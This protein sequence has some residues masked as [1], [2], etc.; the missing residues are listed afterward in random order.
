M[1]TNMGGMPASFS[2]LKDL[3]NLTPE[4][5]SHLVQVYAA[6]AWSTM[7]AA[8]GIWTF[9][10]GYMMGG[11][12]SLLGGIGCLFAIYATPQENQQRK[13]AFLTG[14][15]YCKGL[16]IAP[17]VAS[18]LEVDPS[19]VMYAFT[20]TTVV[21]ASFT[22]SALFA[23]RR[24]YLFLGGMLGST[25]SMMLWFSL[26][27][28]FFRSVRMAW[29]EL[30]IGLFCFSAY[31]LY[32]TQLIVEKAAAGSR[33]VAAHAAEL[34]IDAVAIFVRILILLAKQKEGGSRKRDRDSRSNSRRR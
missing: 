2:A 30:Y 20:C 1:F 27:N 4:I 13:M 22:L 9:M 15:A 25:M 16:T 28:L 21:F 23:Q 11:A 26:A 32:D 6:L 31:V 29:A 24:S 3:S 17:L 5:Q 14:F 10:S 12:L 7:V 34:F 19:I 18:V 8:F 33:D